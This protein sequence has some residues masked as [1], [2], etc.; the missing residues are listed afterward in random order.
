LPTVIGPVAGADPRVMVAPARAV[1]RESNGFIR[2]PASGP[3]GSVLIKELAQKRGPVRGHIGKELITCC[4]NQSPRAP[5]QCKFLATR[6]HLIAEPTAIASFEQQTQSTNP[7][8]L[9][10]KRPRGARPRLRWESAVSGLVAPFLALYIQHST[11]QFHTNIGMHSKF[12]LNP[13]RKPD[14]IRGSG[15]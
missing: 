7:S 4:S 9:S 6:V 3:F 2:S 13:R 10:R 11:C 8:L 1:D 14:Q 15:L 5:L 12:A